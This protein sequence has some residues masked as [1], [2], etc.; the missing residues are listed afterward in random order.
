MK[1]RLG[2][3]ILAFLLLLSSF[4]AA[5]VMMAPAV[6]D[7]EKGIL[8]AIEVDVA[9]GSG[10]LVLRL[11]STTVSQDTQ[12]SMQT[13]FAEAAKLAQRN[14]GSYDYTVRFDSAL[15][16]VNGPSAG[17][18]LAIMA[19][20][21]FSKKK[22]RDDFTVT[23]TITK[24]GAIGAVGGVKAKIDAV[25]ENK[26]YKVMLVPAGQASESG[27]SILDSLYYADY[28]MQKY[29]LTVVPVAN[30]SYAIRIA[31]GEI[32][33][34][35][36]ANTTEFVPSEY[37]ASASS[38]PFQAV[39]QATIDD[40][41]ARGR[42][43]QL[44]D[45]Q[46]K[47][48]GRLIA[49]SKLQAS[50]GYH[51]TAAN[52]AFLVKNAVSTEEFNNMTVRQFYKVAQNFDDELSAMRFRQPNST[53]WEWVAT[54][55]MRYTWAKL[56]TQ[57]ILA[58]LGSND[59]VD[60]ATLSEMASDLSAAMGW[61]EAAKLLAQCS[62]P[63]ENAQNLVP[64]EKAKFEAEKYIRLVEGATNETAPIDSEITNHLNS[65]KE[66]YR[67]G[68]YYASMMDASYSYAYIAVE[69]AL[70]EDISK[71]DD[72]LETSGL[73]ASGV[74]NEVAAYPSFAERSTRAGWAD[75]FYAHAYYN[76]QRGKQNS[77]Y[78][79]NL[80]ALKL[81]A[82]ADAFQRV[83]DFAYGEAFVLP[84][85]VSAVSLGPLTEQ[86]EAPVLPGT[87][88]Q[89]IIVIGESGGENATDGANNSSF[90]TTI[91]VR[92]E[93]SP[94]SVVLFGAFILLLMLVGVLAAYVVSRRKAART[95]SEL[96]ALY[97]GGRLSRKRYDALSAKLSAR[98]QQEQAASPRWSGEISAPPVRFN[99]R[100][101]IALP[102][103]P[104]RKRRLYR[105]AQ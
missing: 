33:P 56:R 10:E 1:T 74:M 98:R 83:R 2:P 53:S 28:A 17:A 50:L 76:Y 101:A 105:K 86:P 45:L 81:A 94:S 31:T 27:E 23:G 80:N 103:S 54:A 37:P 41:E 93:S 91:S 36:Q 32:E 62:A 104:Q 77:E 26:S 78:G 4:A 9:P 49:E 5:I 63:R 24:G 18:A 82:L 11:R 102:P 39:A 30:V 40:S 7:Q 43:S 12:D 57:K 96:D 68:W 21:E 95:Q 89:T 14:Y 22:I 97:L 84:S 73:Y 66:L 70:L 38:L 88:T 87:A 52:T 15:G 13:A 79:S 85:N 59:S 47:A 58:A 16:K 71:S 100:R 8:T 42:Q 34:P 25:G 55:Q 44:S 65:S 3:G 75:L 46:K 92:P 51:Y 69:R 6:D 29:N 20:S 19:Y 99:T 35:A 61:F 90:N 48:F 67:Q 72:A 60:S 64:Q